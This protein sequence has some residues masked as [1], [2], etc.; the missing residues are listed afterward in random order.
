VHVEAERAVVDLRGTDLDQ[1]TQLGIDVLGG[2][3]AQR[4]IASYSSGDVL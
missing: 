1:L 4:L 3:V 2:G